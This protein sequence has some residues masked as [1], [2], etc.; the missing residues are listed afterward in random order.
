MNYTLKY[1]IDI[2]ETKTSYTKSTGQKGDYILEASLKA[3][4]L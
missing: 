3:V 1:K 4:K 2:V